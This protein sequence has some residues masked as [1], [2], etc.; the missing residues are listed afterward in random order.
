ME[1]VT[2][3]KHLLTQY[4]LMKLWVNK[5]FYTYKRYNKPFMWRGVICLHWLS[6]SFQEALGVFKKL[7]RDF[8]KEEIF[9]RRLPVPCNHEGHC[10]TPL[11]PAPTS[12]PFLW[13]APHRFTW[14]S[15]GNTLLSQKIPWKLPEEN[16]R[17]N[18][19]AAMEV[20][21]SKG[22]LSALQCW[23][24]DVKLFTE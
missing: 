15:A 1:L 3:L 13:P 11:T 2:L 23:W 5:S 10:Q 6:G 8:G 18:K 9:L 16:S 24:Y 12:H 22:K 20:G 17:L 21:R 19:S 7:I 4:Y 14:Q